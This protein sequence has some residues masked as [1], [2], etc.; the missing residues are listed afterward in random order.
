M[1]LLYFFDDHLKPHLLKG[2]GIC[3][4]AN[5]GVLSERISCIRQNDV[6]IWFYRK[7]NIVIAFDAGHLNFPNMDVEFAKI[8]LDPMQVEHVFLT[9]ADVDHAGGVDAIGRNIFPKAQV[10]VGKEEEQYLK[11]TMHRTT[12]LGF[13]KIKN[14]VRLRDGYQLVE[15]GEVI[16][17][18]DIKIEAIH[19]PGHTL[20]HYCYLVDDKVLISGDC[21]AINHKGGYAFFDFFTQFPEMNKNSLNRLQEFLED[22]NLEAVCTGHSGYR[23]NEDK[24]FA[25]AHESATFSR[26]KPFDIEAPFDFTKY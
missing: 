18:G 4:P 2:F 6:N 5:T 9:H 7:N 13:V 26:S 19:V 25:F 24:L 3:N 23:T 14:C 12:K 15:E 1:K 8:N 17:V 10:Y 11:R 20:G 22:K 21:L 16:N